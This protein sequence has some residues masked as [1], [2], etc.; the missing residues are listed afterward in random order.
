MV[1][2]VGSRS[3]GVDRTCHLVRPSLPALSIPRTSSDLSGR[4]KEPLPSRL[5]RKNVVSFLKLVFFLQSSKLFYSTQHNMAALKP[6][7][8]KCF[9]CQYTRT[10]FASKYHSTCP[11]ECC[12]MAVTQE[13]IR[14][15]A[16]L[17]RKLPPDLIPAI[18]EYAG[19]TRSVTLQKL[20]RNAISG[21][22]N[23]GTNTPFLDVGFVVPEQVSQGSIREIVIRISTHKEF[24]RWLI[25][26]DT[27]T[28]DEEKA[29]IEAVVRNPD[30]ETG[31]KQSGDNLSAQQTPNST[32]P[33]ISPPKYRSKRLL[34]YTN[35]SLIHSNSR[36][37]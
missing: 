19:L 3:E 22:V 36:I 25:T 11:C 21:S 7:M 16:L 20:K 35:K 28:P 18:L 2:C 8:N 32:T 33:N 30:G 37:S 4:K 24:K 9:P 27:T 29:W 10:Q 12:Q 26:Q 34:T 14:I 1:Q 13:V 17:H 31:Q 6:A 15:A 5:R 23:G